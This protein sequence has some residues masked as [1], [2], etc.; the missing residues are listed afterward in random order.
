MPRFLRASW[1]T[2]AL[3]D[4]VPKI[5]YSRTL[6]KANWN[7][8]TLLREVDPA[9]VTAMKEQPGGDL[10]IAS[11][12][13]LARTFINLGLVD[14]YHLLVN[15]VILGSGLHLF[16]DLRGRLD[17]NLTGTRTFSSGVVLLEYSA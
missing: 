4:R 11:G 7:P 17:L 16:K 6:D 12:V 13:R 14:E 2:P 1:N 8:S 5:V 15:P 10:V 9:E 3:I